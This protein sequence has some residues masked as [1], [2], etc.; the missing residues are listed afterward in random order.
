MEV[1]NM[2]DK[3]E[4]PNKIDKFLKMKPEDL[5]VGQCLIMTAATVF[6]TG[7]VTV[8]INTSID[9]THNIINSRK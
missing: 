7:V 6:V 9:I 1:V 4:K 5:T 2:K 3:R 8:G